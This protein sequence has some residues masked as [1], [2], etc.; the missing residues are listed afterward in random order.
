VLDAYVDCVSE[1]HGVW[2]VA[3]GVLVCRE[4]GATVVDAWGRDLVPLDWSAR[5]TPVAAATA[6]LAAEL[7]ARRSAF[8]DHPPS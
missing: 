7:V 8:G 4:A 1:A 5:R 3:G 2:D 6:K